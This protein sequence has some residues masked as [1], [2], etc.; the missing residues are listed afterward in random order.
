[1]K[2]FPLDPPRVFSVGTV[3]VVNM[4]DCGRIELGA[5][6]QVTFVTEA[7]AEYDVA[8]KSWGFYATP[9][10]NGR[11]RRFGWRALLAKSLGAKFYIVLVEGGKE[12]ECQDYMKAH[13]YTIVCWLD[14]DATLA[15]LER[16]VTHP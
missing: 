5:D 15:Q 16:H 11:L 12:R 8:R 3:A 9:S 1:M 14:S 4:K 2:I 6:E 13:R 7:G 10:L